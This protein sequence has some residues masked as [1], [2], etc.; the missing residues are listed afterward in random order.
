MVLHLVCVGL[1]EFVCYGFGYVVWLAFCLLTYWFDVW[2][3]AW[4]LMVV[5]LFMVTLGFVRCCLILLI[6]DCVFVWL[7]SDWIWLV[8]GCLG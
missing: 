1:F 3:R 7:L 2:V 4:L 6:C 8:V 5:L